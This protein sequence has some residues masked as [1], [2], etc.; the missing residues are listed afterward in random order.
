MSGRFI[1]KSVREN[2]IHTEKAKYIHIGFAIL[3]ITLILLYEHC[4][5]MYSYIYTIYFD[6]GLLVE[7]KT[8]CDFM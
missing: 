5:Y 4:G 6:V 1:G 3:L 7:T 2:F 8:V